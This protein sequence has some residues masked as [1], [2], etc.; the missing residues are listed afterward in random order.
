MLLYVFFL[1]SPPIS[2]LRING[3]KQEVTEAISTCENGAENEGVPMQ[4]KISTKRLAVT[5]LL[6]NSSHSLFTSNKKK[7]NLSTVILF[8][9]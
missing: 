2:I 4:I 1:Y 5:S 7:K 8:N 6:A 9:F 3:S